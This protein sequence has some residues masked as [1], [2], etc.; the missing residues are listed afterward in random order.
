MA[1]RIEKFLGKTLTLPEDRRYAPAEGLWVREAGDR[2]EVGLAEPAVLMA[3]GIR[4]IES[5]VEDGERVAAGDTVC[6]ALTAKLK[7]LASPV[8]GRV[9]FPGAGTRVNEDPYGVPLFFVTP[10]DGPP[11][12]LID[13]AG[14]ARA[15]ADSEGAHNPEG[16]KGGVSSI[17]KA[18]Y[19]GI[20]E[21]KLEE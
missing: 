9:T 13:A 1:V 7:Y 17:C 5:L 4:Q 11:E 21:Q 19:W 12:G 8:A 15:L 10:T 20:R 2:L 3:G 16:A 6:L 18:L 14:Y